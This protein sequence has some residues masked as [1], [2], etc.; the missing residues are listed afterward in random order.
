MY[1]NK[2]IGGGLPVLFFPGTLVTPVGPIP[3]IGSSFVPLVFKTAAEG[4]G[5]PGLP[6][7]TGV[8]PSQ[9]RL[10]IAPTLTLQMGVA[11]CFGPY[12]V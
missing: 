10:Y 11:I 1:I 2:M 3:M 9:V 6:P 5:L 12:S 7:P 4:F 8:Y